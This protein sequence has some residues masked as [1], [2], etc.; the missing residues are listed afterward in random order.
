MSD[1]NF[2]K[3]SAGALFDFGIECSIRLDFEIEIR[4][5]ERVKATLLEGTLS[6]L[7]VE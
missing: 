2:R 1:Y 7:P 3:I 4:L 5:L 6:S